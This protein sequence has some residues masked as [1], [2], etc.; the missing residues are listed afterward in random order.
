M[1]KHQAFRYRVYATERQEIFLPQVSG[2][3]RLVY[4]LGLEQRRTFSRRGRNIRYES[5]RAELSALKVEAE[6]LRD[7]PHH[8]IQEGLVDLGKAFKNFFEGRGGYPTAR[9][10]GRNDGFRFPDPKQIRFTPVPGAKFANLHLP[11][12]G[13]SADDNGPLRIRYHRPIEGEIR[14]VT[15]NHEAGVWFVSVMCRIDT[16][17]PPEPLGEP[18]GVDRGVAVPLFQSDGGTPYVPV[19]TQRGRERVKRLQQ[20][21]ARCERGSVNRKKAVRLL[22][23]RKAREARRRKDALHKA[24]TRLAKNHYLIGIED[25]RV[26]NMTASAAGT[27]AEPGKNV[28]H[29]RGLNR[30]I[31]E[32]GWG[33]YAGMLAYKTVWYG[34][35]LVAVPPM[36]S[37]QECSG[38]G[39]VDARSRLRRDIFR[40]TACEHLEHADWNA[41]K[42]IRDRAIRF[43][44]CEISIPEDTDP[45]S[46]CGA[47]CARQGVEPGNESRKARS[48]AVQGGE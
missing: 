1:V 27:T 28:A 7:V 32:I 5:Q 13:M 35:A 41:S 40:C 25:L 21:I 30:A 34:S 17:D 15:M 37:S 16:Q 44:A 23:R 19:T 20:S 31:L 36:H 3:V 45:E 12:L 42:V 6:F 33:M 43:V 2:C 24:S 18:I 48:P 47:L 22:G 11:K 39:H 46:A 10:K 4:N 26:K 8:C 14:S 9:K 29:K 38:C